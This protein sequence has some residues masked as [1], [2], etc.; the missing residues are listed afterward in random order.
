MLSQ[1]RAV[2]PARP[3]R[4]CFPEIWTRSAQ[5]CAA[6]FYLGSGVATWHKHAA[7]PAVS[8][9]PRI[10]LMRDSGGGGVAASVAIYARD[11]GGPAFTASSS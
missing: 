9:R 8:I 2:H 4:R 10:A 1:S 5:P 3:G 7:D 11:Q 6:W